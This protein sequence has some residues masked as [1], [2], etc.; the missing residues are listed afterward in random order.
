MD[1][2]DLNSWLQDKVRSEFASNPEVVDATEIDVLSLPIDARKWHR[3]EDAVAVVADLKSSTSFSYS[4]QPA[5]TGAIMEVAVGGMTEI[6]DRFGVDYMQ[7]QGDGGFGLFWGDDRYERAMC[8]AITIQSFS[9]DQ[10][11]PAITTKWPDLP[12][13]GFKVG[14]ACGPILVKRV[15]KARKSDRQ[16]PVWVGR[17]VN[18]ASKCAQQTVPNEMLITGSV[19]DWVSQ[20]DY[21]AMSCEC[22]N[23]PSRGIWKEKQISHLRVDDPEAS[24]RFLTVGWC[25][26]HGVGFCEAVLEGKTTRETAKVEKAALMSERMKD[27]LAEK[28]AR[29]RR[30]NIARSALKGK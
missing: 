2:V 6:F 8:A 28:R 12:A 3:L 1:L 27:S 10:F 23:G 24:G 19:W 26:T 7:A 9:K 20:N 21:L 5:S 16:D 14:V 11:V 18:Y 17:P 25:A 4:Q 30:E 13:T 29:V 15:G 22:G